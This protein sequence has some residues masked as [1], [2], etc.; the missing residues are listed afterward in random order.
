MPLIFAPMALLE[1]INYLRWSDSLLDSVA[2]VEPLTPIYRHNLYESWVV[3][4]WSYLDAITTET[5]DELEK[6]NVEEI[7]RR[8]IKSAS[9]FDGVSK[10]LRL[11]CKEIFPSASLA[12]KLDDYRDIRNICAHDAGGRNES[13]R[14]GYIHIKHGGGFQSVS[15]SDAK[16]FKRLSGTIID[17]G[18]YKLTREFCEGMLNF[19]VDYV[20]EFQIVAD[21][22][23]E[24]STR[25]MDR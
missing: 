12:K 18:T 17:N 9:T 20:R 2:D 24:K 13:D 21:S 1:K 6:L 11:V 19:G 22:I 16:A 15:K 14:E 3:F 25:F 7:R 8:D 23:G 10:Y 5:C 4:F